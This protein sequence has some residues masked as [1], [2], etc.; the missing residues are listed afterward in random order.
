MRKVILFAALAFLLS[1]QPALAAACSGIWFDSARTGRLHLANFSAELGCRWGTVDD[2]DA[3]QR[4]GECGLPYQK[5]DLIVLTHNWWCGWYDCPIGSIYPNETNIPL[6]AAGEGV[7]LCDGAT[8]WQGVVRAN[9]REARALG[10]KPQDNFSC[11]GE[12]CGT[13]VTSW[14][15]RDHPTGPA[16]YAVV[17]ISYVRAR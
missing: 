4:S 2:R 1:I 10:V 12:R 15:K 13:I 11:T 6:M 17:I 3:L 16:K 8:L 5:N 7:L 14:G 9:I